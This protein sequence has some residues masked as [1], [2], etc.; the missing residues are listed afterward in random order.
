[1]GF[2][3]KMFSGQQD[4]DMS[5][6]SMRTLDSRVVVEPFS[7][8]NYWDKKDGGK[9]VRVYFLMENPIEGT[10]TGV[11]IDGSGSMMPNFG[12]ES[13]KQLRMLN[14]NDA[15]TLLNKG[16]A[17]QIGNSIELNNVND[18]R[19]M[20]TLAQLGVVRKIPAGQNIVEDQARKMTEYLSGFDADGG[21]TVVYWATGNDGKQVEVIG[22]FTRQQCAT[23]PFPG[24]NNFGNQ[25]H[26]LPAIKYFVERFKDADWGMYVFITD[27]ALNDLADVKRYC[28]QLAKDIE[29]KRRNDLKF[30]LIGVGDDIDTDQMEELDDLDTGTDVDLW[31]HKIAKEMRQLAEIFAEVVSETVV[32][33]PNDGVVRDP[34]GNVLKD[35]RDS[36]LPAL[37]VFDLPPGANS[38]TLEVGGR[39]V[40]QAFA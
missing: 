37:M 12:K 5:E 15:K 35:Y 16:L 11:A 6:K 20:E 29:A 26:L 19:T 24:P 38:F 27:G 32:I 22:D 3:K 30:V 23:A 7:K 33:A 34:N 4:G 18:P 36:G 39:K 13:Y 28:V 21:T 40:T 14:A 25:T 10:Q 31:D 9:R 2:L 1:M 8:I 17:R